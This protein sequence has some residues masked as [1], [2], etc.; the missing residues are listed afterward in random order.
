M[1]IYTLDWWTG[2]E[3]VTLVHKEW[4]TVLKVRHQ[5]ERC[6]MKTEIDAAD[7]ER[8]QEMMRKET[9]DLDSLTLLFIVW[10]FCTYLCSLSAVMAFLTGKFRSYR[11]VD[12]LSPHTHTCTHTHMHA[13]S[14]TFFYWH[15][16]KVATEFLFCLRSNTVQRYMYMYAVSNFLFINI[17][18]LVQCCSATVPF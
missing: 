14:H 2:Y 17:I 4:E 13:N 18:L 7:S 1:A 12:R 9:R 10:M 15:K 6:L 5:H 8:N 11:G 16:K 3:D